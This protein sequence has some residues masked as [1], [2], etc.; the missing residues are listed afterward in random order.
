MNS[1]V[2]E[3][4][5]IS[6]AGLAAL[7]ELELSRDQKALACAAYALGCFA[8]ADAVEMNAK[9]LADRARMHRNQGVRLTNYIEANLPVGTKLRDD[10][11]SLGWR[12]STAVEVTDESLIPEECWRVKREIAKSEISAALKEGREVPGAQLITRNRLSIK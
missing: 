2:D 3:N 10:R 5:E 8:E 6:D 11:V 9:R 12:K 4:G 1:S 7:E